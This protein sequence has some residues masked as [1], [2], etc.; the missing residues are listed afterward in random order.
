MQGEMFCFPLNSPLA[1][2]M[3]EGNL[4]DKV[5]FALRSQIVRWSGG[6]IPRFPS[7]SRDSRLNAIVHYKRA[8]AFPES[9]PTKIK[10]ADISLPSCNLNQRA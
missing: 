8:R 7:S 2:R 3:H 5:P 10:M 6:V 1:Y 9:F 4:E